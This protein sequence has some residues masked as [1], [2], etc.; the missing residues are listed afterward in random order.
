MKRCNKILEEYESKLHLVERFLLIRENVK[1][2]QQ[3]ASQVDSID[4]EALAEQVRELSGR[5]LEE[6]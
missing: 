2:I 4:K 5:I 1:Q 3:L 6:L